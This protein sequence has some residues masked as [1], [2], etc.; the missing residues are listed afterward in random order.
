MG[1][2]CEDGTGLIQF[3][4]N[5]ICASPQKEF[6]VHNGEDAVYYKYTAI[7]CLIMYKAFNKEC[8]LKH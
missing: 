6:G 7:Y 4:R 5:V 8:F 2:W 3:I 1:W